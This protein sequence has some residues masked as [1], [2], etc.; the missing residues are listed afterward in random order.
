MDTNHN[1]K[2]SENNKSFENGKK[3]DK[4]EAAS[5]NK[6]SPQSILHQLESALDQMEGID[7]SSSYE[8]TQGIRRVIDKM[9]SKL[10]TKAA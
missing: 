4:K 3:F 5:F 2:S 10:N 1:S 8:D 6:K 9:H 7:F